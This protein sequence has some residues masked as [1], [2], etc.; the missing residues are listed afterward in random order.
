[1]NGVPKVFLGVVLSYIVLV[2]GCA[3][4]TVERPEAIQRGEVVFLGKG[5]V[6]RLHSV[7]MNATDLAIRAQAGT[8]LP[9]AAPQNYPIRL[10]WR[11]LRHFG[12][13]FKGS[14]ITQVQVGLNERTAT[15]Y[16]NEFLATHEDTAIFKRYYGS[17]LPTNRPPS[18]VV[19]GT[20][21]SSNGF[22]DIV[23]SLQR[24]SYSSRYGGTVELKFKAVE[25][26]EVE[27]RKDTT[28]WDIGTLEMNAY[29]VPVAG[30]F[31]PNYLLQYS[32]LT[33]LEFVPQEAVAYELVNEKLTS[34]PDNNLAELNSAL[35]EI[36]VHL[37]TNTFTRDASRFVHAFVH[38][39]FKD[40]IGPTD[41][42]DIVEITD[43]FL[44]LHTNANAL[45]NFT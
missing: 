31:N 6:Q 29:V 37:L 21:P 27:V 15:W 32:S 18:N 23:L 44:D 35:K 17:S 20:F 43:D 30:S 16:Y 36:A 1:M 26:Y 8:I 14:D 34:L 3:S 28:L 24:V 41:K 19:P 4:L 25:D 12:P 42:V 45:S 10:S 22:N 2:A 38:S 40:Y 9:T 33:Y 39:Q 5:S 11:P 13:F 7:Q